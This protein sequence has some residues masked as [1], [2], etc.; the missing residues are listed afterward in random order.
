MSEL[1]NESQKRKELLKHL[2]RQLHKGDAPEQVR[3]QVIKLMGKVP[4]NEV[5]EVEQ[6]L[7]SDGLPHEEILKLCDLHSAALK[8]AVE[9]TQTDEIPAGHPVH[10]FQEE[11]KAIKWELTLLEKA[12]TEA[13]AAQDDEQAQQGLN[14]IRSHLS[15]LLDVEKHYQRKE[16]LLFS[17]LEKHGVTGPSSV[18]WAKDDEAR[19][20]LKL[21]VE[22]SEQAKQV[23]AEDLK[24]LIAQVFKSAGNAIDEMIFKEEE[25]LFGLSLETLSES[26]W[27]QIYQQSDELGYCLYDPTEKWQPSGVTM[28]DDTETTEAEIKLPSGSLTTAQLTALLNTIPFDL[29]FVD[30]QDRVRYFTQGE[31]RIFARNRAILGREVQRCHPPASVHIVQKIIEEENLLPQVQE[32]GAQLMDLLKERLGQHA[33]VGDIRGR[34]LFIGLEFVA[35][36]E[37]KEPFAPELNVAGRLKAAALE[38]GLICYPSGGT[39]DGLRGDHA[40]LAPPFIISQSE[41]EQLAGIFT[42]SLDQVMDGLSYTSGVGV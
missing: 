30:D 27:H 13:E 20:L 15:N 1:L 14:S 22:T 9:Q 4:Y 24:V 40:M 41:V 42:K 26:E 3:K 17:F 29:T 38:N 28:S 19:Q 33:H 11:N 34:G 32:R 18:M 7:L 16:N 5:V 39:A 25:I 12:Y 35:D 10:T 8:G 37:T 21:A 36:R 31:E 6:E 2:I 23:S